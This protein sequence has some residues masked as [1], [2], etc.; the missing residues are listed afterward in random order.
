MLKSTS[1]AEAAELS[2]RFGDVQMRELPLAEVRRTQQG[3][4][5]L[6]QRMQCQAAAVQDQ[7]HGVL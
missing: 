1:L 2:A 7:N 4:G 5:A 3:G 6:H